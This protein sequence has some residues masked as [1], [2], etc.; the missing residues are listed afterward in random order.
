MVLLNPLY[1]GYDPQKGNVIKTAIRKSCIS[2][3]ESK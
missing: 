3:A 1:L 2:P